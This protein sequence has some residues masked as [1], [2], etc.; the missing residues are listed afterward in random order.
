MT[1]E[2]EEIEIDKE[3][4]RGKCRLF[5]ACFCIL[6]LFISILCCAFVPQDKRIYKTMDDINIKNI[7]ISLQEECS[8]K[9]LHYIGEMTVPRVFHKTIK[10]NDG[11]ILIIGGNSGIVNKKE[12]MDGDYS[13]P[14]EYVNEFSAEIYN[15]HNNK[16][17]KLNSKPHQNSYFKFL[18]LDNGNILLVSEKFEIFDVYNKT[19]KIIGKNE[20]KGEYGYII[21]YPSLIEKISKNELL[22]CAGVISP[23][24]T[25]KCW[26]TDLNDFKVKEI[27]NIDM[28]IPKYLLPADLGY[29]KINDNEI[30]I[31]TKSYPRTDTTSVYIAVWDMKKK[32]IIKTKEIENIGSYSISTPV[33]LDS[34]RILFTGGAAFKYGIYPE[35][36][37]LSW[38]IYD[39]K[40]NSIKNINDLYENSIAVN[41]PVKTSD[42]NF[43]IIENNMLRQKFNPN[44]NKL[45]AVSGFNIQNIESP[46]IIKINDNRLLITGGRKKQK[47]LK[48]AISKEAWIYT[49]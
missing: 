45:E 11:S 17:I 30:L 37:P 22:Q 16:F 36:L 24:Y 44:T 25:N 6:L 39:T 23:N 48:N 33:L 42:G 27:Q 1:E 8:K 34:G 35:V 43:L 15:P 5:S 31:Y 2:N 9:G 46:N 10:L 20:I 38:F 19:F 12:I 41:N 4:T 18:T 13:E 49:F 47:E 28:E 26:I 7:K 14:V 3:K 21:N 32:K 29:I 40:D